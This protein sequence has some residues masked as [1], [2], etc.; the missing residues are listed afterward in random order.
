MREPGNHNNGASDVW[1]LTA[2]CRGHPENVSFMQIFSKY[3]NF[4]Y[5]PKLYTSHWLLHS[6]HAALK[7]WYIAS[8][9][10]ETVRNEVVKVDNRYRFPNTF[11]FINFFDKHLLL[12]F[13]GYISP[14]FDMISL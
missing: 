11:L 12:L 4:Y 9:E 7:L 6:M 8:L 13:N 10:G 1:A 14:L 5:F 2:Y 3:F